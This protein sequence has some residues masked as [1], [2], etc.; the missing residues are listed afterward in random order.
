MKTK[1]RAVLVWH[2]RSG[3]D[4]T[5]LNYMIKEMPKRIGTYHYV[6][7]EFN[8]GR[9]VLWDGIDKDGVPFMDHFPKEMVVNRNDQEMQLTIRG[10]SVFQ[11]VGSD[12]MDNLVGTNPVGI[13]F[14]EYP[15]QKPTVWD[16][17]RPILAENGGW[18]VFDFTPRGMN[19][20]W[21][22]LQQA[23]EDEANWFWQV[24]S[25]KDTNVIS[26]DILD[27]EEKEMPQALFKQEYYCEFLEGAGSF[28]RRVKE[29]V[30]EDNKDHINHQF[31]IGVDLAKYHDWTVITPFCLNCFRMLPQDR[32]NQVDWNLQ[33]SRIQTAAYKYNNAKVVVDATGVGDPIA[34][35]LARSGLTIE[36]FKFTET[37]RR[38]LLDN[39]SVM[40]EQDRIKLSPDEGRDAELQSMTF[41]LT[42][43]GK[44]K[45]GV[46]EGLTDDRVMSAALSVWQVSAPIKE[47]QYNEFK[48]YEA[49]FS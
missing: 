5:A 34:E 24:L 8:Q 40:L 35:D 44:T 27:Q 42:E 15:I 11:I 9:K 36:P 29:N 23:R 47:S 37:S 1:K 30:S 33:K 26:K 2:R 18:A 46:A 31:Q 7:P 6:F 20:G 14:S 32:F 49:T 13:V 41:T 25:V 39:L 12:K 3:K 17:Y 4:L 10:G 48:I 43:T 45:V 16:F 19:H 22:I 38:Q 21:K 28:F